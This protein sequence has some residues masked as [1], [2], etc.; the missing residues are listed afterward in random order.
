MNQRSKFALVSTLLLWFAFASLLIYNAE[1]DRKYSITRAVTIIA[2]MDGSPCEN[3]VELVNSPSDNVEP[4][5][6]TAMLDGVRTITKTYDCKFTV[7]GTDD[8]K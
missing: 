4:H 3:V 8:E 2:L 6:L 1:Q 7:K 5:M